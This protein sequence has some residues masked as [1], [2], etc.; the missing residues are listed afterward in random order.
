LPLIDVLLLRVVPLH[1]F[2]HSRQGPLRLPDG[3]GNDGGLIVAAE[4]VGQALE[5]GKPASL[6]RS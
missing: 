1:A 5:D 2:D 3:L 6:L 4:D